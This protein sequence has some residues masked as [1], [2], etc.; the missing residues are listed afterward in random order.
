[1]LWKSRNSS[2]T[3]R[4]MGAWRLAVALLVVMAFFSTAA[5]AQ[6]LYGSITGIV[7]DAT[8]AAVPNVTVTVT[9]QANGETRS[10]TTGGSGEYLVQN[11]EAGPYTVEVKPFANFG[12]YAQKNLPLAVS[13]EAR[14]NVTLQLASVKSEVTVTTAPPTLQTETAEVKAQISQ[15]EIS[16]LPITSSQGRN[17]ENLY[18]LIPGATAVQEQNSIGGNPLRALS[19]NVNGVSYNTNTTRIDGAVNDYGWL[20]YLLA[21]LPPA[22]SIESINVV[23]N[24]FTAEQG[25]AGGASIAITLKGGTNHYHGSA[26]EYYQDAA[27]NARGYTATQASLITIANPTGSVPKNVF[28]EF[29]ANFGGPVYIPKLYKGKDKLFFFENFERITR[30]Q[31]QTPLE[32]VPTS[33][34]LSGDFSAVA[35]NALLY[36]PQPGGV[37]AIL[38]VGSR[39]TFMSEYGCNCIPGPGAPVTTPNRQNPAAAKMLALWQPIAAK[40]T[41]PNYA[42]QLANDYTAIGTLGYNR[43]TNDTKIIYNPTDR[44]SVFGRYSIAPYSVTDPQVFGAAGGPA[45]DGGQPGQASGRIQNVGLGASHV[46]TSNLVADWDFGYTR[47]VTGA[48]SLIDI[49]DGDFGLNTL[50]IPGTNGVGINYVGQPVFA[51]TTGTGFQTLGNA[52]GANPFLFR[53]NQFTT[54]VNLSWTKGKHATKY[55]FT[56]YHFDLNHF[57]PSVGSGVSNPRGGF[58]FQGSMTSNTATSVTTYNALADMLL[59]LPN[60]GTGIAVAKNEQLYNPNSLRWT[61]IAGYAQDQWTL[62]PKL[63]IN[64]GVRYEIDPAPYTDKHGAF[65]LDPNLPQTANIIVGGVGGNPENA[66]INVGYGEFVPRFGVAYRLDDRTVIRS[67]FGITTDPESFRFLRDQYPSEIAQAYVGTAAGTLSL[68]PNNN[69]ITLTTGIPIAATPAISSGFTSL[70]VTIGTNTTPANVRRGYIESWNLFLQ[71]DLGHSYV[72]NI[73]YVGTHAV[74]QFSGVTLNAAPLPSSSTTC[75]ANGQYNPSSGLTGAC[76]FNANQLINQQH[77]NA[78]TGYVCYNTGGITMNEPLFSSNYN[79]L[80]TQLT[81]N[82]GHNYQY[83]LVYTWSH[84]FDNADNGAGSGST[85]PA[86]SDPAYFKLNRAESGYDRTNNLQFWGIYHLPFGPN[87]SLLTHGIAGAIFGGFQIA[88]QLSHI[89][90]APFTVSPS[91]SAINAN[92]ETE[93]AQLVAPYH[94]LGGHNRTP[95]NTSVSGGRAWFDPTAFANPVE[96]TASVAGNPGNIS[97]NFG[98]TRRNEFRGPGVTNVNASLSRNFKIYHESEFQFRAEAFNVVNH[99][100]LVGNPNVTVGGGTFGYITSFALGNNAVP[101]R[102]IQLSGRLNF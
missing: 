70:P 102:T 37:G 59:G 57:Q 89:S 79:A 36:D 12:G 100:E 69:P 41:N 77:C 23:T 43:M 24:S 60:N 25:V 68:D 55:G 26:W 67:G 64:Y 34:M 71:R 95:G 87:Q 99:A 91:T 66:G 54:D 86:Y 63:T 45:V 96:P 76:S 50:G 5:I 65:R 98:N 83:S 11:L 49:A 61:E 14:V 51:F 78:T 92:G 90:G 56:Y 3:G 31:L 2:N 40:V 28:N 13:Q 30:R 93:Y 39:P 29:G 15:A 32:T 6:V 52:Q 1:M 46:I 42:N 48:Q 73:G 97:P 72:A 80:Q 20:P 53:D 44:T 62:T 94:Q 84:A 7:T 82:V 85:G 33:A 19:V 75:M 16:E 22:D 88:G 9:N 17:F 18:T 38:P 21:Y 10:V 4:W 58:F 27:I 101:Q 8:N 81:H 74:R 35:A 47:Q